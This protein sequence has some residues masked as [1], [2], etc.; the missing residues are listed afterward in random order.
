MNS[1]QSNEKTLNDSESV[2]SPGANFPKYGVL[3]NHK[4]NLN[5]D[6]PLSTPL[7]VPQY[8]AVAK[9]KYSRARPLENS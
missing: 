7:M 4:K 5:K 1:S 9:K 8:P 2:I 3:S 6:L